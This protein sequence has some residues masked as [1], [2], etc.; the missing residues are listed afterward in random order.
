MRSA[1][2]RRR[3]LCLSWSAGLGAASGRDQTPAGGVGK[4]LHTGPGMRRTSDRIEVL[5]QR[6]CL[7]CEASDE[8]WEEE[9]T[10]EIGP[11]C[12]RCHAPTERVGIL[13]RR[14]ASPGVNPH[15]AA[16]G[17]LGG[18]KGGPARAA[19]LGPRRRREIARAA[20]RARWRRE[21]R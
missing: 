21:P 10:D 13:K 2:D 4:D 14:T 18:L 16:L 11:C 15:A 7:V 9:T 5:V 19:S 20:A 8:L 17:R 3:E 6:R 1:A 12:S